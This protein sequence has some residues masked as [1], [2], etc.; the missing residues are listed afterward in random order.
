[1]VNVRKLRAPPSTNAIGHHIQ[2]WDEMQAYGIA[3]EE[4][5]GREI[6]HQEYWKCRDTKI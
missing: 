6:S 3:G 2:L 1:V 4:M 5:R